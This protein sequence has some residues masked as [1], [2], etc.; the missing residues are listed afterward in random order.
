M[1]PQGRASYQ[2][3]SEKF[4]LQACQGGWVS[5]RGMK[6]WSAS[7]VGKGMVCKHGREVWSAGVT[8]GYKGG[9]RCAGMEASGPTSLYMPAKE[10]SYLVQGWAQACCVQSLQH[11]HE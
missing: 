4:G 6:V 8:E 9:A 11:G 2:S 10:T 3:M 7:M 5:R 1:E